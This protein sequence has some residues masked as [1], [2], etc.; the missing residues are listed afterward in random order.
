MSNV[1]DSAY[2]LEKA[3]RE[4]QDFLELQKCMD[5]LQADE[6]AMKQFDLFRSVS[7]SIQQKQMIGET[8]SEDEMK[9]AEEHMARAQQ[10]EKIQKLMA[11][12]Q[13][14]SMMIGEIN[15]I[16]FRPLEELYRPK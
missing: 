4:S 3:I 5:E 2:Q 8:I 12:E 10:N 15:Q 13:R 1:Y 11:Q 16:I 14:L 9:K 6:E 7:T